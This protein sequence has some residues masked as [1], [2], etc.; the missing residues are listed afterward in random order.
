VGY[1]MKRERFTTLHRAAL[2]WPLAQFAYV[3][4]DLDPVNEPEAW[5]GEVHN[6]LEPYQ[7]D[8][9]GCHAA[10][11]AKRV[12]RNPHARVPPYGA[13]VLPA[14]GALDSAYLAPDVQRAA[15]RAEAHEEARM[16]AQQDMVR[17]LLRWCPP[18]GREQEEFA[19]R[20]PWAS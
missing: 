2:R 6:A 20:L 19:G 3:G 14:A 17:A 8:L 7:R 12:R 18:A 13:P 16:L 4:V 9:Y 15:A 11:S 10:L 1:E 5:M